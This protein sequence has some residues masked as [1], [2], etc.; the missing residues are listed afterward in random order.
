MRFLAN[1]RLILI[2]F[3]LIWLKLTLSPVLSVH[4]VRPDLFFI[5]LVFYAFR[6]HWKPIVPL[7]FL[8]GLIQDLV[9]NSFFGMSIAAY[10]GAAAL[11]RL[12]VIRFDRDKLWIQLASLFVFSWTAS[13]LFLI[14]CFVTR[15][16][17]YV[18]EWIV[19]KP[20]L[21][22]FYTTAFGALL[23]PMFGKW[24]QPVLHA[25]Q[26]ELFD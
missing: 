15:S 14:L 5:F 18:N 16:M 1:R 25:K 4:S 17:V 8:M 19:L 9:T 23:F 7:A 10:V 24:L 20:L 21:I 13:T 6:I 26:Y 2:L 3:G 11:L 12:F 22:A